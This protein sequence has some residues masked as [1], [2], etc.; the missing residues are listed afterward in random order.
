[1]ALSDSALASTERTYVDVFSPDRSS[2]LEFPVR[3]NIETDFDNSLWCCYLPHRRTG[4]PCRM[5]FHELPELQRHKRKNHPERLHRRHSYLEPPNG[6]SPARRRL[7]RG[8]SPRLSS[9]AGLRDRLSAARDGSR[10]VLDD[11]SDQDRRGRYSIQA[12]LLSEN[13]T[14]PRLEGYNNA[15]KSDRT[16]TDIYNNELYNPNF[17][18]TSTPLPHPQQLPT[19]SDIFSQGFNATNSPNLGIGHSPV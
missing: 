1:M 4:E 9:P 12:A 10:R 13:S 2:G 8:T 14:L 7:S 15:P 16:M 19:I 18:I 3:R 17:T 6:G 5:T 11:R